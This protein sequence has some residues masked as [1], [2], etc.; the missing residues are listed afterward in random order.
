M[1]DPRRIEIILSEIEKFWIAN[2]DLRLGQIIEIMRHISNANDTFYLEDDKLLDALITQNSKGNNS[3]NISEPKVTEVMC[4]QDLSK[5]EEKI[6]KIYEDNDVCMGEVLASTG[7]NNI[8]LE[9]AMELYCRIIH[10]VERDTFVQFYTDMPYLEND[11]Y[12][13]LGED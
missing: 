13:I 12:K 11:E 2:S 5:T 10:K 9:D 8:S 6:M 4:I 3:N 7:V 1:R